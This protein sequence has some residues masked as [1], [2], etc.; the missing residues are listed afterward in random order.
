VHINEDMPGAFAV[1]QRSLELEAE[2]DVELAEHL[3]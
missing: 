1:P 2:G 3:G